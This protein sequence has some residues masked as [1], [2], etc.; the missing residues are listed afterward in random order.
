MREYEERQQ[1]QHTST[2]KE[3]TE[4]LFTQA[5]NLDDSIE[6]TQFK[7][8]ADGS[9]TE[10]KKKVKYEPQETVASTQESVRLIPPEVFNYSY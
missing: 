7:F 10:I 2:K 3:E 8:H 5:D 9:V 6:D 4:V 1:R